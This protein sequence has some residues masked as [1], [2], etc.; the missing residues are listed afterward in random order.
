MKRPQS[1]K[2]AKRIIH[3][4]ILQSMKR[5]QNEKYSK[6]LIHSPISCKPEVSQKPSRAKSN[7]NAKDIHQFCKQV[8]KIVYT[9]ANLRFWAKKVSEI[10]NTFK[11]VI[12]KVKKTDGFLKVTCRKCDRGVEKVTS[13]TPNQSHNNKRTQ[14][15]TNHS[16][17]TK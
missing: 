16:V 10:V 9:F 2:Y 15:D 12:L 13:E 3:L 14:S 17:D 8:S 7:Q 1:E 4:S 5:R 6:S 11:Q